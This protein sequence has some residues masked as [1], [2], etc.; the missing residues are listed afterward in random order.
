[1]RPPRPPSDHLDSKELGFGNSKGISQGD[2]KKWVIARDEMPNIMEGIVH[3]A[4]EAKAHHYAY[5]ECNDQRVVLDFMKFLEKSRYTIQDVKSKAEDASEIRRL[6]DKLFD[7]KMKQSDVSADLALFKQFF[8]KVV[9]YTK[10]PY[11]SPYAAM[12]EDMKMSPKEML[13]QVELFLDSVYGMYVEK[14]VCP[15]EFN[16]FHEYLNFSRQVRGCK[17]L[18][19]QPVQVA[20]DLIEFF[21]EKGI[22]MGELKKNR[23]SK[24]DPTELPYSCK[25]LFGALQSATQEFFIHKDASI[26]FC[27]IVD[28]QTLKQNEV[29]G[30]HS[31]LEYV[32][33][34][35]LEEA[36][37]MISNGELEF[38]AF[39]DINI[40]ALAEHVGKFTDSIIENG[41]T[42][43]KAVEEFYQGSLNKFASGIVKDQE[44]L[45]KDTA[46]KLITIWVGSLIKRRP[47]EGPPNSHKMRESLKRRVYVLIKA[48]VVVS[49]EI[50]V[51]VQCNVSFPNIINQEMAKALHGRDEGVKAEVDEIFDPEDASWIPPLTKV[52]PKANPEPFIDS[53]GNVMITQKISI[54]GKRKVKCMATL[55][56]IPRIRQL[57]PMKIWANASLYDDKL[58][59]IFISDDRLVCGNQLMLCIGNLSDE[60]VTLEPLT[61]V[62]HA[63]V[64]A[65][66]NPMAL[67][68][69]LPRSMFSLKF[70]LHYFKNCNMTNV[71]E[72]DDGQSIQFG[73][74]HLIKFNKKTKV[75]FKI[76]YSEVLNQQNGSEFYTFDA[77]FFFLYN[78]RYMSDY[79]DYMAEAL[80]NRVPLVAHR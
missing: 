11:V 25:L 70:L 19:H 59:R 30:L 76:T 74:G 46:Q 10:K 58:C 21:R 1:M 8:E 28:S 48:G 26:K 2:L 22:N 78:L 52:E 36:Y 45:D 50:S 71:D 16:D 79:K 62:G 67:M 27:A 24:I 47:L 51:R 29:N 5:S 12:Q 60:N 43:Y 20:N 34:C 17:Y 15:V 9:E 23:L 63:M 68:A 56:G 40:L 54:E 38:V 33:K 53:P 75:N 57:T 72:V 31:F 49:K 14:R 39:G 32:V 55:C 64:L 44:C 61:L 7:R 65:A 13:K 66:D 4:E 73:H 37:M 42:I 69:P 77:I 6:E 41:F 35:L 3:F 80:A 18:R